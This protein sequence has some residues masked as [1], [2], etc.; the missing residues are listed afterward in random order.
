M[1][2]FLEHRPLIGLHGVNWHVGVWQVCLCVLGATTVPVINVTP[3]SPL[4]SVACCGPFMST[5]SQEA[6]SLVALLPSNKYIRKQRTLL[7]T[8]NQSNYLTSASL[9]PPGRTN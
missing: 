9:F 8:G 3:P 6:F 4:P 5:P 7:P 1:L 2:I